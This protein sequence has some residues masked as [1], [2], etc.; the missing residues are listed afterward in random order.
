M[1]HHE[2]LQELVRERGERLSAEA[3]V[4]RLAREARASGDRAQVRAHRAGRRPRLPVWVWGSLLV[5]VAALAVAASSAQAGAVQTEFGGLYFP[6]GLAGTGTACTG[7]W[8]PA[9]GPGMCV[10]DSG[11]Q[12]QLSG[13]RL[14]IRGLVLDERAV[15]WRADGS[16][17]PR[18]TGQD[19]VVANASV[20]ASFSGPVWGTF[21][22]HP[23]VGDVFTGTFTGNFVDGFPAV[24]F[25]GHGS[26][27]Y[28]GQVMQG[29]ITREFQAWDGIPGGVN[30]LGRFLEPGAA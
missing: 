25:I 16:P 24:H 4:E 26:G 1:L 15:S 6:A 29:T 22:F 20:D 17:E 9:P 2:T 11:Q 14:Q 10:L 8:M 12:R 13:G 18:K 21:T 27:V 28:E 30:M 3:R 19:I 23:V 5:L 7:T